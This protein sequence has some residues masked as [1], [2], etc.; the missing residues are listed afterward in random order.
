[1]DS[2]EGSYMDDVAYTVGLDAPPVS[3]RN[4]A[5][6]A[7]R[8]LVIYLDDSQRRWLR[9]VEA[10]ALRDDVRLPA[11]AI[12]RLALDELRERGVSWHDLAERLTTFEGRGSA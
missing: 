8:R 7:D 11:S 1:M 10:A 2:I 3:Q 4:A 12:I 9:G 6:Q 5:R